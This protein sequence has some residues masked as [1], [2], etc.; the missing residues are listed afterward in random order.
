MSR[1]NDFRLNVDLRS[2]E[3]NSAHRTAD[4]DRR[5]LIVRRCQP[6]YITVQCSDSQL[7]QNKLELMLHLG[8][9]EEVEVKVHTDR[10]DGGRWWFDRERVQDELLLTLRSPSDAIIGRYYLTVT[11]MSP[12]GQIIKEVKGNSFH[13]LF[14]PW[15]KDD[16]VYLDD[17]AQLQEYVMNENG[18]IFYGSWDYISRRYWN[19]GQF[20]DYVMDICLQILDN[21][22]KARENPKRDIERRSDP[23]YISRIITAMVNVNDDNGVLEGR[24]SSPYYDGVIP[25]YWSGSVPILRKWSRERTGV[26]YGQ[27]WVFAAV[28]CTVLR[29]LGIPTRVITNFCSAHD[30]DGNL[31]VDVYENFDSTSKEDSTWNFHCWVESWMK[32]NDLPRGNDGWQILDPTP[33][34]RSDGLY[35][36]G[37]CPVVAIKE[38]NLGS[39]VKYDARFIFAEVNA[40][41][42]YWLVLPDNRKRMLSMDTRYVGSKISTKSIHGDRR[43]DVTLSYKY[44]EGSE[45]ERAVYERAGRRVTQP[46]E[47]SDDPVRLKLIIKHAKCVFGTDFD[48]IIEVKNEG[49]DEAQVKLTM[50]AMAVTYNS[51]HR[52]E[53]HKQISNVTV[54]ANQVHKQVLRLYYKDYARCVSEHYLIRVKV[55][56]DVQGQNVPYMAVSNIHLSKPELSI[57]V[58]QKPYIWEQVTASISFTNPL[59]VPLRDG[60]FTAEGAG[61]LSDTR[62][63]VDGVITPGEKVTVKITF[64]PRKTG[65][66]KLLVDFDSDRLR[67]V[68]GVAVMVV[69]KRRRSNSPMFS[70]ID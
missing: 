28:A 23:I 55:L 45:K 29:C 43:E 56:A 70:G 68:K 48:V 46:T 24:W 6:F 35:C 9:R 57:R 69:Y 38:G 51:L 59:P 44:P 40:D 60:V 16:V 42:V 67:D 21:S 52:G 19:Y 18:I 33:Q 8:R 53:C 49:G 1:P 13:V 63:H 2:Y 25:V 20:E 10:G 34:E 39:D 14:N 15:C 5:R 65:V 12:E 62:L 41:L 54:P 7:L 11:M 66:K 32:R 50:R 61:L 27:C 26:K 30:V 47:L 3:N 4:I 64:S 17:D 37:P 31:A 22:T 58:N 36:C